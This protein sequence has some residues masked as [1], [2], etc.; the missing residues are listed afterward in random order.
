MSYKDKNKQREYT[1]N[2]I[3]SRRKAWLKEN[4][5]CKNCGSW[6]NLE[7]DHIDPSKKVDH[8]VWSWSEKRRLEEL[9]KCQVLCHRCHK[10]KSIC[11]NRSNLSKTCP[12]GHLYEENFRLIKHRDGMTR[13]CLICYKGR[14]LRK[15]M[16]SRA[17]KLAAKLGA[18]A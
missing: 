12:N 16:K 7:L 9:S 11:E 4:D 2:W 5:P 3:A 18:E 1:K 6:E 8:K 17:E 10:V 15:R 13:E 14:I